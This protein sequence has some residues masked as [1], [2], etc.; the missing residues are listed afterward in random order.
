MDYIYRLI[1]K[2]RSLNPFPSVILFWEIL[3]LGPILELIFLLQSIQKSYTLLVAV[4]KIIFYI[5]NYDVNPK[6]QLP[7]ISN[8]SLY[9]FNLLKSQL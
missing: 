1:S 3:I 9:N 8:F 5:Y 6:I 7:L 4:L 2:F